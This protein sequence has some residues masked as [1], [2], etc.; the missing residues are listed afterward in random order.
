MCIRDSS[1]ADL[2]ITADAG[3]CGV[4]KAKGMTQ[5][6]LTSAAI[7]AVFLLTLELIIGLVSQKEQE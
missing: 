6:G 5:G 7:K 4:F 1:Y 3:R 2:Y